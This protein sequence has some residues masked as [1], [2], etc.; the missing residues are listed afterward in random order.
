MDGFAEK[1]NAFVTSARPIVIAVVAV[2]LLVTGVMM[3]YPSEQG[4]EK[5]KAA[6]PWVVIGSAIALG[7]V[8]I[9]G[10]IGGSF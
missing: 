4:K 1:I 7:A 6:L 5:A 9:A 2:A 8:T 3:I 10:T